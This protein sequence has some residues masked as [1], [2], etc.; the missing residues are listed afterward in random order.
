MKIGIIQ[1]EAGRDKAENLKNA[2]I[3]IKQAAEEGAEIVCLSEMFAC[4]M[5]HQY[6]KAFAEEKYGPVYQALS[7]MAKENAIILIGGSVPELYDN[8]GTG[9]TE[10]YNTSWCFNEEGREIFEH[11][12]RRLFDIR[13]KDGREFKESKTF[14]PGPEAPTSFVTPYGNIGLAICFEIRFAEDFLNIE[15][16]GAKIIFVPANFSIPTGRVHWEVLFQARALDNQL[17]MVGV[18]S[19]KDKDSKFMSYGHS[20][21]VDPWGEVLWQ[22]GDETCV[23]VIDIDLEEV[24]KRRAELPVVALRRGL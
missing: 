21:V 23:K 9:R 22:A 10:L 13:L 3:Y 19:A 6:Y 8:K 12:K 24:E 5:E 16:S 14:A 18:A 15:Q 17:F 20:I 11:K 2:A 4:P 7:K 1:M